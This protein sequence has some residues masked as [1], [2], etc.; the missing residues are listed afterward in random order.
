MSSG[1]T[2]TASAGVTVITVTLNAAAT[3]ARNL[4]SVRAQSWA[5]IEHLVVD[6]GSTDGTLALLESRGPAV[7]WVSGPDRGL[8][9][10]MNKGVAL[11]TDPARYV[12]FLN[13]D[14]AFAGPDAVAAVMRAARGEDLVYARLQRWDEELDDRDLI[15]R[16]VTERDMLF[17]MAAHHQSMFAR[18]ALFDSIGRFDL[19]YRIAADYDWAVRAFR[20]PGVTRRFVPEVVSVMRRG[21]LSD[22]RYLDSVRERWRI[23]R[24]HYGV[25]D[26]VRYSAYTG[27]GDYGRYWLQQGLARVGLLAPARRLKRVLRARTP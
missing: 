8:Y 18:R 24:R 10:A 2:P 11:V 19:A 23:V 21:G 26:L 27:I 9:D 22:R 7:R 15:G 17:G 16:E 12:V 14:D 5:P 25:F 4:D 6:G 3:L 13:A 20:S 1:A